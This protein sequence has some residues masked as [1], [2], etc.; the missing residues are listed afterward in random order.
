MKLNWGVSLG[1]V[2]VGF[3]ILMLGAVYASTKHD[4]NLVTP[5][6][7]QKE[8]D[9]QSEIDAKQNV[10][11]LDEKV[12]IDYDGQ[13]IT[14]NL[15]KFEDAIKGDVIFFRPSDHHLDRRLDLVVTKDF[16][17]VIPTKGLKSGMWVVKLAWKS[18]GK[19]Y[20]YKDSVFL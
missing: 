10:L 6:Y 15:P 1:I 9:Y 4:V 19:S 7:Y 18:G 8:L 12:K 5:N 3:M 14:L 11:A 16:K 2:Y 13:Q 17:M 20:Q